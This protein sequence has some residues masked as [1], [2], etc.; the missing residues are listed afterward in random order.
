MQKKEKNIAVIGTGYWGKNLV[1]N[2]YKLGVLLYI[3]DTSEE[4]LSQISANYPESKVETNYKEI[5][6]N[7]AVKAVVIATPAKSHFQMALDAIQADKDVFVEKPLAM[8]VREAEL[9]NEFAK[10]SNKI[11]MVGHLLIFHPAI[12]KLKK[13]I[14][15]NYLGKI[16]YIYSHRL[17]LGKVRREENIL[18]SFAPHD[19]SVILNLLMEEPEIVNAIGGTYLQPQVQDVTLTSL[20]FKSGIMAYIHVSWLH[21]F[22][23]QRLVIVGDKKMAVFED[24][25][26]EEK[27]K[28]YDSG[29]DWINGEPVLRDREFKVVEFDNTEPL[30]LECQHFID[31]IHTRTGPLTDGDQGIRVLKVLE[32]AQESLFENDKRI[33]FNGLKSQVDTK[34]SYVL[35]PTAT[36]DEP[37]EIGEGT[38]IWHYSHIMK[39]VKIGKNCKFGQN[40]FVASNVEIGDN[41]KIQNNVSVYEGVIL[42]DYVFCGP[43]MVFTNVINPRCKYPQDSSELYLRTLVK[44]GASIGANA[45]IICGN[46]IGRHAFIAAGAVVTIDVPDYALVVGLPVKIVGWM[47]ECG[48]RLNFNESQ[49][50]CIKCRKKYL[51]IDGK[52]QTLD[53]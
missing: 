40:V 42:E 7:D 15:S 31:C 34:K 48:F 43:S 23:E 47:C 24:T 5:L 38:K 4:R 18:W 25:L 44:Y 45:T 2:F 8:Y 30:E 51:L 3:C 16:H 41:V 12:V 50:E 26:P 29:V 49:T 17:N 33:Y 28:I 22:K 13:L 10:K 27:L 35:H 11:L 14:D 39:N 37:C 32:K 46:I 52:V 19:I 1:R 9:L 20:K 53:N 36:V 21:P 6:K